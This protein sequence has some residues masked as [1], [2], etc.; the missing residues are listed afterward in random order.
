MNTSPTPINAGVEPA[1]PQ[2]VLK[3]TPAVKL[4]GVAEMLINFIGWL[5]VVHQVLFHEP[6]VVTSG[7]DG[8]HVASSKHPQGKAV[9][10]RT[11]DVSEV[12]ILLLLHVLAHACSQWPI[13]V[14]DERNLA[15]Q[16]HIHI[17]LV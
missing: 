14:F 8:Q 1:L 11:H 15:G 10:I 17:E 4:A 7:T 12:D 13:A 2:F 6:L 5:G 9:D 3:A 16:G